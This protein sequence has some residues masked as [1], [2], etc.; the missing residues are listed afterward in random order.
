[1]GRLRVLYGF[2]GECSLGSGVRI[3]G[4]LYGSYKVI[5]VRA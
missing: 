5:G 4:F 3:Q 1:M 2:Y